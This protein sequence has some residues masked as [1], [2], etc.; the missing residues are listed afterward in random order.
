[1]FLFVKASKEM[2]CD[3]L[4]SPQKSVMWLEHKSVLR[5]VQQAFFAILEC[6]LKLLLHNMANLVYFPNLSSDI[7]IPPEA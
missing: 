6:V 4:R 2:M 5:T 3:G 1:M 7:V